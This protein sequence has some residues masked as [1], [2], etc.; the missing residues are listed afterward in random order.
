MALADEFDGFLVDLDGVVW[1][2]REMVPGSA[3]TLRSLL[4]AGKEIV[5]I[6]NNPGRPA[7]SY[8]ERLTESGI[9]VDA[10]RVVTAGEVT[11]RLA[12]ERVGPGGTARL[13]SAPP[14]STR[15]SRRPACGCWTA[16]RPARPTSCSSPGTVASITR[17]C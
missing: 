9:A 10:T 3:E 12:A 5:F 14:P 17:S 7:Y 13:R 2:G 16:R 6:T 1:V 4:E 15:R 8:A 11:A